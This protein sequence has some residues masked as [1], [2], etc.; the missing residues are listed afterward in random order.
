MTAGRGLIIIAAHL[1][2]VFNAGAE[3]GES[4]IWMLADPFDWALMI[5]G[6]VLCRRA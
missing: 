4:K 1:L 3:V 2:A 6:A 5:A